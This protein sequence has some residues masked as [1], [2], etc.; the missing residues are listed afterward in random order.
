ML[1][2]QVAQVLTIKAIRDTSGLDGDIDPDDTLRKCRLRDEESIEDLKVRIVENVD[3]IGHDIDKD[4]FRD[5]DETTAV[6]E[7]IGIVVTATPD[8]QFMPIRPWRN[9]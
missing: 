2:S 3:A 7:V 6:G 9:L 8:K 5:I 4:S 1:D